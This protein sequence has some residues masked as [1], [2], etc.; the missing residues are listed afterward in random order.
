VGEG[1]FDVLKNKMNNFNREL[2]KNELKI[3]AFAE[4]IGGALASA[5]NNFGTALKV[6]TFGLQAVLSLM[7]ATFGVKMAIAI[8][9]IGKAIRDVTIAI[10]MMSTALIASGIGAIVTLVAKLLLAVGVF[11]GL[12]MAMDN[13]NE[14]LNEQQRRGQRTA[15]IVGRLSQTYDLATG[16]IQENSDVMKRAKLEAQKFAVVEEQLSEITDRVKK[17]FDEA[18]TS[19]SDAFAD[20]VVSGNSFKDAMKNIFR[21]MV[22]QIIS[23][24]THV[25]ILKPLMDSLNLQLEDAKHNML[26]LQRTAGGVQGGFMD[27]LMSGIKTTIGMGAGFGGNSTTAVNPT[28]GSEVGSVVNSA[29]GSALYTQQQPM[30]YFYPNGRYSGGF[31]SPSMP[32]MVGEKGAELFMPK[33]AGTI[34]PNDKMGGGGVTINQSLN[35]STGVVPTVRAE[36][37]NLMPVIKKET[38]MAVAEAKTR[39]GSFARTFGS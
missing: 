31:V 32:Y 35:F 16:K 22:T 7:L 23:A 8:F 11:F 30:E 17:V 27:A 25:L 3:N 13:Y 28:G 12:N 10:Y 5:I 21:S 24:V 1:F 9:T 26:E 36:I 20:A 33:S 18:G 14:K 39:G 15:E 29:D 2:E 37:K 4:D 19:I 38:V 6:L 34:I